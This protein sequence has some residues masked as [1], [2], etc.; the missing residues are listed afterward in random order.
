MKR[1]LVYGIVLG[2]LFC[3]ACD[4]QKLPADIAAAVSMFQ[5]NKTVV[6]ALAADVKR[7]FS[8]D[9]QQYQAA[10]SAYY[11]ARRSYNAYLGQ[12][13]LAATTDDR[14][15]TPD[16]TPEEAR[17][18]MTAFVRSASASLA[19]SDRGLPSLIAFAALPA[20]HKLLSGVPKKNRPELVRSFTTKVEWRAWD[21]IPTEEDEIASQ[22]KKHRA[23]KDK[24]K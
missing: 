3:G 1:P 9:T 2:S 7:G 17:E 16:P 6:E 4:L 14:S 24:S 19:P 8:P 5:Q 18:T 15:I 10:Q 13:N 21:Q 12:F 20:I 11:S 23:A 22:P